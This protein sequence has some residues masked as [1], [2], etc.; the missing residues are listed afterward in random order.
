[1]RAL[2]LKHHLEYQCSYISTNLRRPIYLDSG[3]SFLTNNVGMQ[4]LQSNNLTKVSQSEDL[5][6]N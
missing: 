4:L 3:R 2:T 1:M 6:T 5:L